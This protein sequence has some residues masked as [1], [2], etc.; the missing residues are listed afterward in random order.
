MNSFTSEMNLTQ[1]LDREQNDAVSMNVTCTVK[2]GS[3]EIGKTSTT[4]TVNVIGVNDNP[5]IFSQDSSQLREI[6]ITEDTQVCINFR[7]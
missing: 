7:T 4:V 3:Q 1:P 2:S 6:N 5:L